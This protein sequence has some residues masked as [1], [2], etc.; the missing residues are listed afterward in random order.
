[1]QF[2]RVGAILGLFCATVI[3]SACDRCSFRLLARE[4]VRGELACCGA[5]ARHDI[6]V[7]AG[8]D[9]QVDLA[10]SRSPTGIENVDL[11]LAAAD[12]EQLF[13]GPYPGA[14]PLCRTYIGPVAQGAVTTRITLAAGRYRV[15]AQSYSSDTT[16]VRYEGDVGIWGMDCTATSPVRP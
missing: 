7:P 12:C 10:S 4:L 6:T 5:F 8:T 16:P 2:V 13:A 11:W 14:T 9:R 15:F 1:M 3:S